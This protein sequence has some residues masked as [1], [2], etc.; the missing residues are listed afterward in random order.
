MFSLVPTLV[1][2]RYTS[3]C[4]LCA[5]ELLVRFGAIVY[6]GYTTGY[7]LSVSQINYMGRSIMAC[8]VN[9]KRYVLIGMS[10]VPVLVQHKGDFFSF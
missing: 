10:C 6:L 1:Y 5:G 8:N 7:Q 9:G 3:L 4:D 2:M